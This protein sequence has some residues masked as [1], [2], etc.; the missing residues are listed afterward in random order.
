[1]EH[2]YEAP[3]PL[4]DQ[5]LALELFTQAYNKALFDGAPADI[6][7]YILQYIKQ[8]NVNITAA[9]SNAQA[10]A[11]TS[12]VDASGAPALPGQPPPAPSPANAPPGAPMPIQG[13][14]PPG[15]PIQ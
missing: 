9:N 2:G 1:V 7:K 3:D 10:Q 12:P 13:M 14:P 4:Q 5:N 8:L 15:T 11:P 6:T